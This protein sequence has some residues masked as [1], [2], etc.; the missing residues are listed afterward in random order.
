MMPPATVVLAL[1]LGQHLAPERWREV[2]GRM[3]GGNLSTA[4]A[5]VTYCYP[6]L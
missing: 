6:S 5:I 4:S 1:F 2:E 3:K